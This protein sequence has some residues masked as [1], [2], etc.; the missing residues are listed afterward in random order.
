MTTVQQG[1]ILWQPTEELLE[2]SA[3]ARYMR[4]LGET[5][6]LRFDDYQALW[7]WSAT[8]IEAFWESMWQFFDVKASRPYEAWQ[9]YAIARV[10][11]RGI[12]A[13]KPRHL[14]RADARVC[15]FSR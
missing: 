11:A 14:G 2:H 7:R 4:W 3:L 8:E 1:D 9:R 12:A 10:L 13:G 6:G 15:A 5:R